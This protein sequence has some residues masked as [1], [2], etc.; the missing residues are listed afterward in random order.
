M[1]KLEQM[2]TLESLLKSMRRI[3][4]SSGWKYT[5]QR[6]R[7]NELPELLKIQKEL[8][9]GTYTPE[10]GKTFITYEQGKKRL[11]HALDVRDV[12]VQHALVDEILTPAI[13]KKIIYDNAA[14]RKGKGL[15]FSR[16]RIETH[17]HKFYRQHGRDGYILK[18]DCAKFFDNLDHA[19]IIKMMDD[20]IGD[21]AI[22]DLIRK[23]LHSNEADISYTD[24][25][26]LIFNSL[27]H[28]EIPEE[29]KTGK[30]FLKRGIGI[31]C[32]LAQAVGIYYLNEIDTYCKYVKGLKYYDVYMDDRIIIHQDKE[33]LKQLLKEIESK[34]MKLGL[35]INM[36][37]T[38]IIRL[39]RPFTFLKT[40]YILTD[41]GHLVR[42]IPRDVLS[43]ERRKL[44]KLS[45]L[46]KNK[47][48]TQKDM[49]Q[50]YIS[51]RGDKK[52]YHAGR[53]LHNMDLL[54]RR[55]KK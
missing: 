7:I 29:L 19:C 11:I 22:T 36:N 30:R 46:V 4:T 40:R 32:A 5:T 44:K 6:Y 50:Q 16:R 34:M 18:I 47:E 3:Y 31:G 1:N 12:I 35:H 9:E 15:S 48:I 38:Q 17:I 33:F 28:E 10:K 45:E 42:K 20:L 21:P 13:E 51:W 26:I 41:T 43:R 52:H 25:P 39:N 55:L 24:G 14:S 2:T 27:E 54:Y 23:I 37:K 8:R 49:D 53:T